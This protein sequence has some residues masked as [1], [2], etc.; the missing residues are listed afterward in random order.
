MEPEN[1]HSFLEQQKD[2]GALDGEGAFTVNYSAARLKLGQYQLQSRA[3]YLLKFVQ[4]GVQMGARRIEFTCKTDEIIV[5]FQNPRKM[6][7]SQLF[8][9]LMSAPADSQTEPD[10]KNL[11]VAL[12]AAPASAIAFE[13]NAT[14]RRATVRDVVETSTAP[15]LEGGGFRFFVSREGSQAQLVEEHAEV[16]KRC[17][18]CPV[19]LVWDGVGLNLNR[20]SMSFYEDLL[21]PNRTIFAAEYHQAE[22]E[23]TGLGIPRRGR[24]A[25]VL[26]QGDQLVSKRKRG[27][28]IAVALRDSPFPSRGVLDRARSLILLPSVLEGSS[29]LALVQF[30][31]TLESRPLKGVKGARAALCVDGYPTDLTGLQVRQSESLDQEIESVEKEIPRLLKVLRKHLHK[32]EYNETTATNTEGVT[33]LAGGVVMGVLGGILGAAA[34]PFGSL[35]GF[36]IGFAAGFGMAEQKAPEE[37]SKVK[38]EIAGIAFQIGGKR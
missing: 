9:D 37:D 30:G 2:R 21:R 10:L 23:R 15:R 5:R 19:P 38:G 32:V 14:G 7:D 29:E 31:V 24:G 13:D 18:L 3:G 33:A 26:F 36:S 27:W 6:I 17:S 28:Q 12:N 1:F 11:A 35:S 8:V 4:A 16:W 34:G 20:Q 22:R 25:S